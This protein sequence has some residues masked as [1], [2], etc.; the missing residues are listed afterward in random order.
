M[1]STPL[2]CLSPQVARYVQKRRQWQKWQ[3]WRNFFASFGKFGEICEF[4][5]SLVRPGEHGKILPRLL[6]LR[7]S[8]YFAT[9]KGPKVL[10]N[11]AEVAIL[12]KLSQGSRR[13]LSNGYIKQP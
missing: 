9:Q 7:L 6:T 8:G 4:L 11:L 3:I 1:H 2:R 12:K 13:N 5:K 10:A